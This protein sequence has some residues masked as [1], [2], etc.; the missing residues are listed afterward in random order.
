MFKVENHYNQWKISTG[1][2]R[3]V[4]AESI[5]EA[6]EAMKHY[7]GKNHDSSACPFCRWQEKHAR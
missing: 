3:P 4:L 6:C 1:D 5:D 7:Y 2:G